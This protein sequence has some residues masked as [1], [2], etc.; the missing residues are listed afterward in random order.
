MSYQTSMDDLDPD[1][2]AEVIGIPVS[3]WPSNCFA[4]ATAFVRT[5]LVQ[6]TAKY[7]MWVGPIAEGN[8]FSGRAVTHHG[9]VEQTDAPPEFRIVDPTRWVFESADPYIYVGPN[10]H[11][12]KGGN[13][14]R[15]AMMA[16]MG[17]DVLRPPAPD[18]KIETEFDA[19]LRPHLRSALYLLL[20]RP[21]HT[22]PIHRSELFWLGNLDPDRLGPSLARDFYRALERSDREAI[23]PMDNWREVMEGGYR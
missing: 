1:I 19:V 5:K 21:E 23:V 11:Y 15:E 2:A 13:R 14:F 17:G 6:G 22:G 7:G 8:A 3:H 4:I 16:G 12:D 10:D 9:W 18:G 20:G